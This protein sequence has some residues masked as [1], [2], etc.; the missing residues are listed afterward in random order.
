MNSLPLFNSPIPLLSPS[1]PFSQSQANREVGATVHVRTAHFRLRTEA[2]T[3][4]QPLLIPPALQS[5]PRGEDWRYSLPRR[6]G[7]LLL[8][9]HSVSRHKAVVGF[10][11]QS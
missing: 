3:R 4:E 2:Q 1:S 5:F 9:L 6:V 8:H 7:R 11:V 10:F